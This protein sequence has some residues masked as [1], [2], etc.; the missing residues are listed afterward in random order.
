MIPAPQRGDEVWHSGTVTGVGSLPGQDPIEAARFVL[1]ELSVPHLP[2]LPARG[3]HA[4]L[5]GR[6]A[7]LL[8]DLHV[9][10]Q[11]SG[12]RMVPRPSR[13]GRRARDLLLR[14][15]DAFEEAGHAAPPDLLKL[16]ATGPWTL[17][18]ALELHRGDRVLADHGAVDDLAASLAEGLRLHVADVQRRFPGTTIV[19][20]LDEPSLPAV[21]AAH[22]PTSSGFRTLRA[23]DGQ[24][25]REV[26]R[27][28][29]AAAEKTVLH[30]CA[31]DP[32]LAL[33][34][35]AGAVSFDGSLPYDE[36][37]LGEICERGTGLLLG[38]APTT[39]T[40]PPA[41]R[42]VVETVGRLR[43]RVGV[44]HLT[45]TPACGLAGASPAYARAVLARLTQAAQE[46]AT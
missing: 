16:Q 46:L 40:A 10:L 19:L 27:T 42:A 7:A 25:A 26:L 12:W 24:R 30:C 21:L 14:D 32:P 9:D 35:E 36:D 3:A 29:L 22:V 41:V 8:A 44:T 11:P 31:P 23:P 38:V 34:A 5:A 45:L 39:G 18:A 6:G 37:V 2:E 20:Q 17:A 28:V 43:D 1:G 15:L 13:D 4:D 33:M